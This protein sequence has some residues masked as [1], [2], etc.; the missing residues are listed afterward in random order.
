MG[1]L[2]SHPEVAYRSCSDCLR[3]YYDPKTGQ[4][5]KR[6]QKVD[7]EQQQVPIERKPGD[8][9]PCLECPKCDGEKLKSP[10]AGQRCELS[11]RNWKAL[12]FYFQQKAVGGLVDAIARKNCGIIEWL[13]DQ[14]RNGQGR[15]MVELLKMRA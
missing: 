15:L 7:G 12:R 8:K 14:H 4:L 6:W 1:L 13:L 9:L 10:E 3:W 11:E 2:L 5:L